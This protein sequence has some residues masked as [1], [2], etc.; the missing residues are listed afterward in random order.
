MNGHL[1]LAEGAKTNGVVDADVGVPNG[2]EELSFELPVSWPSDSEQQIDFLLLA[3]ILLIYRGSGCSDEGTFSCAFSAPQN[4][5]SLAVTPELAEA[6]TDVVPHD[7][8]SLSNIIEKIRTIRSKAF[9]PNGESEVSGERSVFLANSSRPDEAE[10]ES[11]FAIEARVSKSQLYVRPI[12]KPPTLSHSMLVVYINAY[13]DIL[14]LAL[15]DADQSVSQAIKLHDRELEEVWKWNETVPQTIDQG[16]HEIVSEKAKER[17]DSTAVVSWDGELTYEQLERYSTQLAVRLVDMGVKVDMPVPL[18]FEKSVWTVV[19]VLA[20]MKAGGA[21]ALTDPS[22]P[23]ARLQTIADEVGVTIIVTSKKQAELG[24]RIAPSAKLLVVGPETFQD[25]TE[26]VS[27]SSLPVVPASSTLYIIF[28]SG[29]TGKPKGVVISH[30]N[31]TSGAL[32]RAQAVGYHQNSRVL[33]FPSYAFDVSIDCML[34]TLAHGG[35]I[36]VPSEDERVN[37]LSGAIRRMNVNMA[38]MTPS[39]ARVLESD[40]L[41]SLEVLGLGGESVSA[42]DAAEWGQNTKV[43]IAYGPSECTVGCTINNDITAGRSYTSIGKGVGGTTWIVNPYDHDRLAPVGAVGELLVEGPLV[44]VGYLNDP[45]KTAAVFIED[46][47]WMLEGTRGVPGRNG[48]LYKTGD[49]VRYDPD[50]SGSIVFVG[51]GDQQ[52][53]LRGQRVELGEIEHHLRSQLPA[54]ASVTAE[55]ISPGGKGGEATLV[56]FISE[57]P[58][59]KSQVNGE[60][61]QLTSFSKELRKALEG[62]DQELTTVLPRYMVPTTY[63][64]LNEMPL[65][66]SCKTDR[67]KLRAI[68]SAMSRQQLAKLKAALVAK[69]MPQTEMEKKLHQLWIQLFG[70]DTEIGANDNFFH[71]GGDSLKAMRLVATARAQGLATTVAGIFR[72][73]TLS[74]MASTLTPVDADA[75]VEVPPF[76]LLSADWEE[77]VARNETA[78]L[79]GIDPSLVE[80][81]YQCTPLQEALMAL[82]AKISEAYVAQRVVELP[83]LQTAENLKA[84]F[85]TAVADSEILRTRIVQIPQYG[86]MQVVVKG[87]APWHSS[88]NLEEY[89]ARDRAEAMGLGTALARFAVIDDKKTEKAHFVLTLHH[90]LYDGWSMPLVV[91]RVNQAYHGA[92]TKRPAAFNAFIKYLDSIDRKVSEDYWTEQLQGAT[93]LQFPVIPWPGYQPQAQSLLE[94]YVPLE[95][96][97]ASSTSIA[98]AIRGAWALIAGQYTASDDVVIG[99]TLTGRNAPVPGIEEIEGPM[100]TTIPIRVRI[101]PTAQA[102]EYLQSIHDETV[103]RIPHEHMGLQYIRRLNK[104]ARE[105]CELRT[106]LV[107]HPTVDEAEIDASRAGPADGFVPAGDE[108]AAREALKFNTYALMLVF[109]IDP[110]GFLVMASFDSNTIDVPHMDKILAQLGRIVQMFCQETSKSIGEIQLLA[111]TNLEEAWRFSTTGPQN[112]TSSGKHLLRDSNADITATWI[113]DPADSDRLLPAGAVGEL[114]IEGPSEASNPSL[115]NP[116]WLAAGYAEFPGRQARLYKTDELAK[117]KNDGSIVLIG[118]K[119]SAQMNGTKTGQPAKKLLPATTTKQ[120]KLQRLWSRILNIDET[121]IGLDDSFFDLGGDSIGA[122]KLVSEAR[123][124]GLELTVAQ[125][126]G[127]RRFYDMADILQDTQPIQVAT[128]PVLPFSAID[129]HDVDAFVFDIIHPRLVQ[130]EWKIIDVLPTRPLQEIATEGTFKLPRYSARYE[131]FY[132]DMAVDRARLFRSCQELVARNEIL[133][134]IFVEH[135]SRYFGAVVDKVEVPI[136]EYEIE[137]DLESFC[138]KLCD[139]DIQTKMPLGTPFVKFLFVQGEDGKSCLLFRISHAQYD[140]ICLPIM[141]KQLSALYEDKLVQDTIPF[142]TY[143]QHVVRENIPLSIEY[144]K[145]LLHGSTMSVIKP[146]TPLISKKPIA[147]SK[148]CDISTR[149]K[150]ITIATLPTAAW[151]LCL[152]RRLSVRDVTFGEV[153]SGRNID[154]PNCDMVVGPCWQYVPARVKF[155]PGWTTSD[156]LEFVQHQHIAGTRFEGIGLKEIVENCTDWPKT[157]DW[158]DS[159][160][161]QDVDHVENLAFLSATSRMETIYP[162]LEPLREVKVQAFPKGDTICIEIVTFESWLGF[163]NELLKD[164]EDIMAQLVGS[165]HA[166]LF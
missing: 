107:I 70:E 4:G 155:E 26:P 135:E 88:D 101:D 114:L 49:L 12:I 98:T 57:Q 85:E 165:P 89:L 34:C 159:V 21:L 83:D 166:P 119:K 48:R 143:V 117:Y 94:H 93:G 133:R 120:R 79:C 82:S 54:S 130:P 71:L 37:D 9:V 109:S 72:N 136:E 141:L 19:G 140:E 56:A 75:K 148:V 52:V 60:N 39:V 115:D 23:E 59:E 163:A 2:N 129:V 63:I 105:A 68:G 76:S 41:P 92:R 17:P 22:Q 78:N 32:P 160:V 73:P 127:H 118:R 87:S 137:G 33:D 7:T 67:K 86:L 44:G 131:L 144:W 132:L 14:N 30:S 158:F 55:V 139:L 84:A 102:S 122:M 20:V 125:V 81:I 161:H 111:E 108:E 65:L 80:D 18:C 5:L 104:D 8:E 27:T 53:K 10:L 25:G 47:G 61:G 13:A 58:K 43:I 42:R 50:G 36:C 38:H 106:G 74:G 95:K 150:E 6:V 24:A 147:V 157:I 28:T 3:W 62:I 35:C 96:L 152:A 113:V 121:E 103:L 69:R 99:E 51:R 153:V 145:D 110:K 40:I 16:I 11:S 31:Y 164:L 151:A 29:S 126:F 123:T 146:D 128:E 90:A 112:L 149:S 77:Q 64:P 1:D 138:Q 162:H 97:S 100:I 134:T 154:L 116:S 142:S 124:E 156:L 45:E 15:S 66:V 46:L 91:E